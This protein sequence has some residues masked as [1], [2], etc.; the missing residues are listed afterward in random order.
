MTVAELKKI[1][2]DMPDHYI[3]SCVDPYGYWN[4][5][6]DI[7]LDEEAKRLKIYYE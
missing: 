3:V 7:R 5:A 6:V 2:E 4:E 1:I